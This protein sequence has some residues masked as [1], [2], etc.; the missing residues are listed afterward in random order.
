MIS[1]ILYNDIL[2]IIPCFNIKLNTFKKYFKII[3]NLNEKKISFFERTATFNS[4][5]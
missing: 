5:R 3:F 1:N 2:N 4:L